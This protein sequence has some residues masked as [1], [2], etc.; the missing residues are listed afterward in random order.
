MN[1]YDPSVSQNFGQGADFSN[2]LSQQQRNLGQQLSQRAA[3]MGTP[4]LYQGLL[5]QQTRAREALSSKAQAAYDP[6]RWQMQEQVQGQE[7]QLLQ[8]I[9][10]ADLEARRIGLTSGRSV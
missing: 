10:Q 1:Q 2:V 4:D 5:G 6:Q 8:A 7:R 9:N 3:A